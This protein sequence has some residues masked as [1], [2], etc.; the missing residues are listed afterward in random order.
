VKFTGRVKVKPGYVWWSSRQ[1]QKSIPAV[2]KAIPFSAASFED[3]IS[4]K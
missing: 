3:L 1:A 4:R 2:Y